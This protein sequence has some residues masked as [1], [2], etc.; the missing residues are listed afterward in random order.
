MTGPTPQDPGAPYGAGHGS[1]S[2]ADSTDR[3]LAIL[4]HLSTL[5]AAVISVGWLSI[6]GPLIMWLVFKNSRPFVRQASAGAFNFAVGLW[7]AGLIAWVLVITVI[8]IPIALII[9]LVVLVVTILFPVLGAMRAN[10]GEAYSYPIKIPV[11][12]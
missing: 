12:S 4:A 6:L 5:I 2:A 7:V 9:G 10:K 11:L 3:S 8:G 1:A